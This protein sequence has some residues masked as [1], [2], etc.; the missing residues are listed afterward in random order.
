VSTANTNAPSAEPRSIQ[1]RRD[2]R[3]YRELLQ[4]KPSSYNGNC[5]AC[6]KWGFDVW[7]LSTRA[8]ICRKCIERKGDAVLGSIVKAER[9]ARRWI[10]NHPNTHEQPKWLASITGASAE[11]IEAEIA[12]TRSASSSDSQSNPAAALGGSSERQDR[13]SGVRLSG[14]GPLSSDGSAKR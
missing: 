1:H 2:C 3:T 9:N 13:S 6:H 5:C 7:R 11:F 8:H 14:P 10:K 4:V 12:R